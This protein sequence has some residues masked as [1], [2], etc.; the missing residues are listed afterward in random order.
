MNL[1]GITGKNIKELRDAKKWSQKDLADLLKIDAVT[2]KRWEEKSEEESSI[3]N[4]LYAQLLPI[5]AGEKI[6]LKLS[7]ELCDSSNADKIYSSLASTTTL[8][9]KTGNW[10]GMKGIGLLAGCVVLAGPLLPV[11]V[12][13]AVPLAKEGLRAL[14][15]KN[16]NQSGKE[17]D[18]P[19]EVIEAVLI[20]ELL[21]IQALYLL[22]KDAWGKIEKDYSC[23]KR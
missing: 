18:F 23:L 13:T 14:M 3:K 16:I 4:N 12:A 10:G 1:I 11:L 15:E 9:P 19:K 17:S 22:Q 8:D 2:V 20:R 7:K 21:E 5:L 6:T